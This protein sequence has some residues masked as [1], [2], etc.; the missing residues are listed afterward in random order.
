[1]KCKYFELGKT[2]V[3][4][5]RDPFYTARRMLE[6]ISEAL[7]LLM[8]R[9]ENEKM[10]DFIESLGC[11]NYQATKSNIRGPALGSSQSSHFTADGYTFSKHKIILD[12]EDDDA[13]Y[14]VPDEDLKRLL[15]NASATEVL[16]KY[17]VVVNEQTFFNEDFP[18]LECF[19]DGICKIGRWICPVEV[20]RK[21]EKE[22][23]SLAALWLAWKK[24]ELEDTNRLL[25]SSDES[26]I[27]GEPY[28]EQQQAV[29]LGKR[30]APAERV[31]TSKPLTLSR[32]E[33]RL[34]RLKEAREKKHKLDVTIHLSEPIPSKY[35]A[36]V[37]VQMGILLA[38]FCMLILIAKK[39]V[40]VTIVGRPQDCREFCQS[41]AYNY[42]EAVKTAT[43]TKVGSCKNA[44]EFKS[45]VDT[46]IK[47]AI[48][49]G[50]KKITNFPCPL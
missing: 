44:V 17:N 5:S 36:Q 6:G 13:Q 45:K 31:L 38:P 50:K 15:R 20:K 33:A 28:E 19:P 46:P 49:K 12:K 39:K 43:R 23:E 22:D 41:V 42:G 26:Y 21:E 3:L 7:E 1:M 9:S 37:Y 34:V 40:Q 47:D 8:N 16:S 32:E 24:E 35:K 10:R 25:V 48:T 29:L 4:N 27:A 18:N 30:I 2:T 11:L 14:R